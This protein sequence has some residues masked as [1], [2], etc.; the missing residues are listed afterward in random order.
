MAWDSELIKGSW[1]RVSFFL[2]TASVLLGSYSL[3][4][5]DSNFAPGGRSYDYKK[6]FDPEDESSKKTSP[7]EIKVNPVFFPA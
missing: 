6:E 4:A 3:K 7:E 1:A 5:V 2:H